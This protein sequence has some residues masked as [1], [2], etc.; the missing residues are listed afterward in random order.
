[1]PILLSNF[2]NAGPT[3]QISFKSSAV[4]W[5][6]FNNSGRPSMARAADLM[7]GFGGSMMRS[8]VDFA[9]ILVVDF[10]T[11][12]LVTRTMPVSAWAFSVITIPGAV[13]AASFAF[14][15]FICASTCLATSETGRISSA[16]GLLADGDGIGSFVAGIGATAAATTGATG[17]GGSGGA[18]TRENL[19]WPL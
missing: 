4:P 6:F 11:S 2:S 7:A 5:G 19:R 10:T 8:E 17:G 13:E 15:A 12:S 14:T 16:G 9:L 3:P 18:S 1:M